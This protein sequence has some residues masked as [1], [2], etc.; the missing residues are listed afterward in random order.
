[1]KQLLKISIT[2]IIIISITIYV[3]YRV[4][5]YNRV[6]N[7]TK[8]MSSLETINFYFDIKISDKNLI[9]EEHVSNGRVAYKVDVSLLTGT[10][11]ASFAKGY[12][13][14]QYENYNWEEGGNP[15]D[16]IDGVD[17][18]HI[19][20]DNVKKSFEKLASPKRDTGAKSA[21]YQLFFIDEKEKKYMYML[22][23]G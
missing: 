1:M 15:F 6:Y 19:N 3:A 5:E 14:S 11:I 20:K 17:W 7:P 18:W 12:E 10:D 8:G 21:M 13:E 16:D 9:K 4:R 23:L 22:Y 2:F